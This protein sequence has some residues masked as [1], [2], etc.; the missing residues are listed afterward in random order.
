[1]KY[2]ISIFLAFIFFC[3]IL[4]GISQAETFYLK[5]GTIIK[6][7]I[8]KSDDHS[9][10]VKT[11]F[12][13]VLIKRSQ[14]EKVTYDKTVPAEKE[15]V[16]VEVHVDMPEKMD[17]QLSHTDQSVGVGSSV[18]TIGS[19]LLGGC[20]GML[21]GG[22][23]L[24]NN[25]DSDGDVVLITGLIG[26]GMGAAIGWNASKPKETSGLLQVR[27]KNLALAMPDLGV[28]HKDGETIYKMTMTHIDF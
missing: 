26:I 22:L 16:N 12:G 1:M 20:A 3:G 18:M 25:E 17:V 21:I 27:E 9:Y 5:D 11:S 7:T 19:G 4:C 24:S 8:Q 2:V 6:G 28:E 23:I 15:D 13:E 14:I 10:T